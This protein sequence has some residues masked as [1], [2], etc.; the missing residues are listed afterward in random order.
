ML[1]KNLSDV[2][3]TK[4]NVFVSVHLGALVY[5]KTFS[6]KASMWQYKT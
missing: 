5:L 3:P 2:F 1:I 6:V 4:N